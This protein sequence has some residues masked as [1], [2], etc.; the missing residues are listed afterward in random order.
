MTNDPKQHNVPL[1]KLAGGRFFCAVIM[2][3][4]TVF[5]AL[6]DIYKSHHRHDDEK[7]K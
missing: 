3:G 7:K 6:F 5:G 4:C 1:P 2:A